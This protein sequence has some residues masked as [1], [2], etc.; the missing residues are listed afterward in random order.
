MSLPLA[1]TNNIINLVAKQDLSALNQKNMRQFSLI[2]FLYDP[3]MDSYVR[4]KMHR[5]DP[6]KHQRIWQE[7]IGSFQRLKILDLACG[8]GKLIDYLNGNNDY[9]GLDLSYGMLKRAARRAKQKGLAQCRIV[10]SNAEKPLP[11]ERFD[12]VITDTAL[13]VIPDWRAALAAAAKALTPTGLLICALPVVGID[14]NFDEK[15]KKLSKKSRFHALD[16]DALRAACSENGLDFTVVTTNGGML[17]F[18]AK[19]K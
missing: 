18:K 12:L 11:E 9:T 7:L 10:C 2:A 19:K 16:Q 13:H 8:T 6:Q 4:K 1:D 5:A 3:I 15:W 14:E 17:Y